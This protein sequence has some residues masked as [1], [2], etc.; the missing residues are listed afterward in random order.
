MMVALALPMMKYQQCLKKARKESPSKWNDNTK[1]DKFSIINLFFLSSFYSSIFPLIYLHQLMIMH[2]YTLHFLFPS[3][4][5]V[6]CDCLKYMPLSLTHVTLTQAIIDYWIKCNKDYI[7]D[8]FQ[9]FFSFLTHLN[10]FIA[11]VYYAQMFMHKHWAY[12]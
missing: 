10:Y 11:S 9:W 4:I 2:V 8:I 5:H 7:V 1:G 3:Q 6:S 12:F